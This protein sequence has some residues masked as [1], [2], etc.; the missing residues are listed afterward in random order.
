MTFAFASQGRTSHLGLQP[1]HGLVFKQEAT[2]IAVIDRRGRALWRQTRR[3]LQDPIEW[4]GKDQKGNPIEVG[5]YLLRIVYPGQEPVY[6][7][8]IVG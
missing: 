6:V 2:E 8:F 1:D 4:N 5:Q 7:P 3:S